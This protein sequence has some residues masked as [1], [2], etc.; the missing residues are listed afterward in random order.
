MKKT[1]KLYAVRNEQEL[2]WKAAGII[3]AQ[4]ILKPDSVLGLATGTTPLGTYKRLV[5]G[6][7]KGDLDF[8]KVISV[9]LDEYGGLSG[10]HPQSYRFYMNENFFR[11]INIRRERTFLPD[12]TQT[13]TAGECARY[14]RLIHSLGGVDLQLLGIGNN[15]HIGFNEPG[16]CFVKDTHYVTL[17]QGTRRANARLFSSLSEVPDHAYTMGVGSIMESRRIL[18]LA[19]GRQKASALCEAFFRPICPGVPASILQLHA[20]V[21]VIADEAALSVARQKG[22]ME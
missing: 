10:N 1:W 12:G 21:T 3:S 19:S 20:N 6:Y 9:N 2:S 11:H 16:P 14:D 22:C 8:S 13:D 5:E 4:I 17:S 7:R 15:G 18:L